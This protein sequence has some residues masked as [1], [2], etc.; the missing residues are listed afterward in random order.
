MSS[1]LNQRR[2][3]PSQCRSGVGTSLRCA[4]ARP[5]KG[6]AEEPHCRRGP[7][8]GRTNR[9]QPTRHIPGHPRLLL[10]LHCRVATPTDRQPRHRPQGAALQRDPLALSSDAGVPQL[11][12]HRFIRARAIRRGN[13]NG[14]SLGRHAVARIN[15]EPG[16]AGP[17]DPFAATLAEIAQGSRYG[18]FSSKT[19]I[20]SP[21]GNL[22]LTRFDRRNNGP[23]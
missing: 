3:A 15:L 23:E 2:A 19:R 10:L 12:N 6:Q 9:S 21:R 16:G 5:K 14:P 4:A 1:R 20:V 17:S 7:P 8:A 22:L 11:V 18:R 13:G